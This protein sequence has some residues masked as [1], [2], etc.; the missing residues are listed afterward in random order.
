MNE[1]IT[2]VVYGDFARAAVV[3]Y[4]CGSALLSVLNKSKDDTST[5]ISLQL[6]IWLANSVAK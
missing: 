5:C 2:L 6:S 4:Q 1:Q 3:P